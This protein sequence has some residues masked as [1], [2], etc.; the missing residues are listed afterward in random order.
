MVIA[1][2]LKLAKQ[3]IMSLDAELILLTVLREV[4]PEGVDRSYLVAHS[5]M[6]IPERYWGQLEALKKRRAAGEPQAYLMRYKEFYGRSFEVGPEVLIPRP[7]TEELVNLALELIEAS[8]SDVSQKVLPSGGFLETSL[9]TAKKWQILEIGTGSGCIAIT[10]ALEMAKIGVLGAVTAVDISL[11]AL[12]QAQKNAR[13]L[14][15]EVEFLQS[16]LLKSVKK[17]VDFDILIAN[18]PYVDYGWR[19]LDHQALDFEPKLALYAEEGGLALYRRLFEEYRTRFVTTKNGCSRA[20]YL[21]LEA[22]P[23]QHRRLLALAQEFELK[24]IK[25]RGFGVVLLG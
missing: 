5:D 14:G 25:T 23:C 7:E 18:L 15:A 1:T 10:L 20:R 19:W 16:N 2:W 8:R 11:A 9:K 24:P 6:E 22:D 12:E 3:E 21:V 17:D 4:L 13:L